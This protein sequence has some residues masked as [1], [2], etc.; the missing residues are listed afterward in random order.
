M[1]ITGPTRADALLDALDRGLPHGEIPVGL[2]GNQEIYDREL[3]RLF[4]RC[5]VFLAHESE[6]EAKG[7]YVLRKIGEDSF[8]VIRDEH[9][10]IN[11]LFDACRH[12]GVQVCRSD[13][14]NTS[15]FRCPY[16]G[17]TY[18]TKG[19]LVGAPLWRNAFG[20]MPKEG[21]GLTKAAKVASYH[22][23]VFATLD[24]SAPPLEEY[25]GGM[26]WYLDLLFGLNEHG[27]E[28]VGAPQRFV[29]DANWKSGSDNFAGDDYHLG[30]LH[31]SVWEIGAFPVP[32]RE[33]M[34]GYHVQAAP[35][36]SLS[37]SMA[38]TED[39]PGPKFFGFPEELVA[40]F[41]T[42][43]ISAHQLDIARRSRVMV[44]NVFP[45]F[46][47]LALPMTEDGAHHPPTGVVT[48]RTWQPHGVGQVEIWNWFCVYKNMT[49][50]QKDRAYRA[51]LGTFSMGGAFEM[52][53]TEPWITVSRTGRSVAADL[54]DFKLNYQ[55]GMPGVGIA[56]PVE[57]WPGPGISYWTRYEEGV[58][59]NLYRFYGDMMRA[60]PGAWPKFSFDD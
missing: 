47:I 45:N 4:G 28:I 3:R 17:W 18:N 34:M 14:G 5:W 35:G 27:M 11:V 16:H 59:R 40:T 38:P 57:D 19:D 31:R 37:F 44:A 49:P 53:D 55:M 24:P 52:D 36:H 15:H 43:R 13:S 32:F 48:I 39:E 20:G 60:E 46:S 25:L 41:D 58:Q 21:N 23:L 56:K 2:F 33:N 26:A 9:G 10:G 54:L 22:G 42:S 29:I 12:R 6:I 1:T 30:T 50:A 8:I 51:G 7:D